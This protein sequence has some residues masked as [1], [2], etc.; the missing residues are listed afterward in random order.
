V[1]KLSWNL[2]FLY[3][4]LWLLISPILTF[5]KNTKIRVILTLFRKLLWIL[6]FIIILRHVIDF[7]QSKY[8]Y[9]NGIMDYWDYFYW[10]LFDS[11]VIWS[12]T[13]W[14]IIIVLLWIT[15]NKISVRKMWWKFWKWLHFL[16]FPAYLFVMLHLWYLGRID[17]FYEGFTILIIL[18]RIISTVSRRYRRKK[19]WKVTK[20]LCTPC[21]YIY[22]EKVWDIDWW[23]KPWTKFED[24]PDDWYC[25][26]CGVKKSDFIPY[27]EEQIK[28]NAIVIKNTYLTNNVINLFIILDKKINCF[29][30]QY[31]WL[32]MKDSTWEF[33]RNYSIVSNKNN[34]IELYIKLKADWK[35]WNFLKNIKLKDAL[36]ITWV[37]WDFILEKTINSKVFIATWTGLAPLH[38]MIVNNTYSKNNKLFFW[39]QKKE[40]LF[41]IEKLYQILNL[42]KHIFLSQEKI[43]WYKYWRIN[44]DNIDFEENTEFYICWNPNLVENIEKWLKNRW[45]KNIF[46]EKFN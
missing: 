43:D 45:Y 39:V 26:I 31:I 6:V 2:V 20:Y 30:W 29:P 46:F 22:D 17:W 42:E 44:I 40:D 1:T 27:Y 19:A 34:I 23:L 8:P 37:F 9:W 11:P 3:L 12:G 15:S 10:I 38:N 28:N 41:W 13:L 16:V 5:I 32:I 7:F 24:I 35:A 25:P 36:S 18:T 14:T 33:T 4:S 21:W